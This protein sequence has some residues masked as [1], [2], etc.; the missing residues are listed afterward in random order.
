MT[1]LNCSK[2]GKENE[3][4]R[5]FCAFCGAPLGAFC[6]RCQHI[7][8]PSDQYCG[9]CGLMLAAS[10]SQQAAKPKPVAKAAKKMVRQ[11]SPEEIKEML[12]LR[13]QN[14]S[15]SQ[16]QVTMNQDEIDNLFL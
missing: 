10:L 14:S 15:E 11:Y 16:S 1:N 6:D 2:C 5:N 8:N 12:D 9:N 3:A 4:G 7:I 13:V